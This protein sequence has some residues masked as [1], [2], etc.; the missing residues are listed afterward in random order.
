VSILLPPA[1]AQPLSKQRYLTTFDLTED[2]L[3]ERNVWTQG[4][5]TGLDWSNVKTT[6]NLALGTQSGAGGT[7]DSIAH[8]KQTFANNQSAF[9]T[10]RSVNQQTGASIIFEEVELL[11]RFN[12]T[13]HSATGYECTFG[14]RSDNS[15]G[16]YIQVNR[17]NG[18]FN[19][20]TQIQS[21]KGPG[22]HD[23]DTIG[24]KIVGSNVALY[25]NNTLVMNV[26]DSTFKTGHP[27][28]GFYLENGTSALNPDFG[29]TGWIGQDH[30]GFTRRQAG[31]KANNTTGTTLSAILASNP[32][33]G[34]CVV[35][36]IGFADAT[37]N[38]PTVI[39]SDENGNRYEVDPQTSGATNMSTSG[40]CAIAYLISAPANA[41]KTITAT[42][43]KAMQFGEIMVDD[44][45]VS[46]G[47]AIDSPALF[48]SG[49]G[50]INGPTIPV[51]TANSMLF[52]MATSAGSVTGA[53]GAWTLGGAVTTNP[54]GWSTEYIETANNNTA[55]GFT[56]SASDPWNCLAMSFKVVPDTSRY[57]TGTRAISVD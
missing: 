52:C 12:I 23:G 37:N 42:F 22:L 18:A 14:C 46:G 39:I 34:D 55:C 4:L 36:G 5:A 50:V 9:A 43:S 38:P 3:S 7:N 16:Q 53:T 48:A 15:A 35:V 6:P 45:I 11:L 1:T 44:F 56:G 33:L 25:I 2:P 19:D 13:A 28:I 54:F 21:L 32:G 20:F 17:W 27:G 57:Y 8:L 24:A 49:T 41:G 47:D 29:L 26:S 10:V 30:V 40:W 31:V 51:S